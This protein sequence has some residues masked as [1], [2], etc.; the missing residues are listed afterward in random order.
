MATWISTAHAR[1][2]GPS[3][4]NTERPDQRLEPRDARSPASATRV[5][6]SERT[7]APSATGFLYGHALALV[8]W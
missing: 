4:G 8:P 6:G 2:R 5:T 7:A 1:T 3:N